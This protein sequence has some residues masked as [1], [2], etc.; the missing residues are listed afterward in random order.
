MGVAHSRK[1]MLCTRT[2][3]PKSAVRD[4]FSNLENL[5]LISI[6]SYS[7]SEYTDGYFSRNSPKMLRAQTPLP[8][9]ISKMR[10]GV[11]RVGNH[12]SLVHKFRFKTITYFDDECCCT[13]YSAI[14]LQYKGPKIELGVFQAPGFSL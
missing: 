6:H 12:Y 2:L 14:A 5:G 11:L 1:S 3:A 10:R 7:T 8:G 13:I 4:F 9:P